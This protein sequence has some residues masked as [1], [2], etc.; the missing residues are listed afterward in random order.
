MKNSE[1][2]T[3]TSTST[4]SAIVAEVYPKL[5]CGTYAKSRFSFDARPEG[6][7]DKVAEFANSAYLSGHRVTVY[8][9]EKVGEE[10]KRTDIK[11]VDGR[12]AKA[13]KAPKVAPSANAEILTAISNLTAEIAAVKTEITAVKT[14]IDAVK[15]ELAKK[16]DKR[17]KVSK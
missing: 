13:P 17:K 9:L 16:A 15:A 10:W 14:E 3:L 6:A 4:Y 8:L 7:W 11:S 2:Y 12:P 5:D 1:I